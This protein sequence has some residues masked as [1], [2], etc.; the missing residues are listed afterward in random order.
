MQKARV[1]DE[2]EHGVLDELL[3]YYSRDAILFLTQFCGVSM[4]YKSH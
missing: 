3:L 1:Q 2:G 4:L